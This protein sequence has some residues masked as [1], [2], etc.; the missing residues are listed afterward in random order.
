M[1]I[2]DKISE[3]V[4]V[5]GTDEKQEST[6]IDFTT[7]NKEGNIAVSFPKLVYVRKIEIR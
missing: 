7:E 6:Y 2:N 4:T 3:S 5:S 1:K